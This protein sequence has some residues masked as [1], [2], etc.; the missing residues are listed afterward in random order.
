MSE[1]KPS[2]AEAIW[3]KTRDAYS[4]ETEEYWLATGKV[5]SLGGHWVRA[6]EAYAEAVKRGSEPASILLL[7]AGLARGP[8]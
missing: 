4:S 3:T 8:P 1:E 2:E 6:A 7:Q 5:A